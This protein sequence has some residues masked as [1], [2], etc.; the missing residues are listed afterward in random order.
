[1][2]LV[3]LFQRSE[4]TTN[5]HFWIFLVLYSV[6][7]IRNPKFCSIKDICSAPCEDTILD[8]LLDI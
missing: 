2:T 5:Q 8:W 6:K 1:M 4:E 3:I 7:K